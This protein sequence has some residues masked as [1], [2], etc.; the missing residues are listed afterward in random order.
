VLGL[1]FVLPTKADQSAQIRV[2]VEALCIVMLW[3]ICSH[4][5]ICVPAFVRYA[6]EQLNYAA[7]T[8]KKGGFD[9]K[10]KLLGVRQASYVVCASLMLRSVLLLMSVIGLI[11]ALDMEQINGA[12]TCLYCA[13]CQPT[14]VLVSRIIENEYVRS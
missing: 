11:K 6:Q 14:V 13:P 10:A 8:T 12:A 7:P 4:F 2:A 3:L 9:P 5:L 1:L